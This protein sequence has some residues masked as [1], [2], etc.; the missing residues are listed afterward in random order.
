MYNEAGAGGLSLQQVNN[1]KLTQLEGGVGVKFAILHKEDDEKTYNPD[2]HFMML[3]DFKSSAPT[4]TA[5]FLGGGGGFTVQGIIPDKTTYN[6][7]A[8]LTFIHQD[9]IHFTANYELRIKNK[10]VG[11]AGSLAVKYQI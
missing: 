3:H 6:V 9:R 7:G 10:Y 4:T 1:A 8:G 5:Q 11:H 2:I